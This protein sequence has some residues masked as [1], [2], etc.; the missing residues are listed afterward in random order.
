LDDARALHHLPFSILLPRPVAPLA[1]EWSRRD[2]SDIDG[3]VEGPAS[4][5]ED[6]L[7]RA[8]TEFEEELGIMPSG[9]WI[10]L[11]SIQQKGG[12]T[13]HAWAFEGDLPD[14]FDCKSNTFEMEWP[15]HSGELMKFPEIDR[16][17]FFSEKEARQKINPAQAEFLDRL[18]KILNQ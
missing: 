17:M 18:D 2:A 16:A 9:D 12:K 8:Q 13:V 1:R 10:S 4:S 6:L 15:P 7:T 3:Q 11:G 5:G 14:S